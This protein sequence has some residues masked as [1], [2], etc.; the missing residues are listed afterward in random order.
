LVAFLRAFTSFLP[1]IA[2]EAKIATLTAA[3]TKN[4]EKCFFLIIFSPLYKKNKS[5]K[6]LLLNLTRPI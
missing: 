6:G 5:P 2:G 1:A 3:D 4:V